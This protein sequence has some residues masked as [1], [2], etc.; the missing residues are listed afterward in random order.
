MVV[1]ASARIV[2]CMRADDLTR[3]QFA[4]LR[5]QVGRIVAYLY[6]LNRRMGEKGFPPDDQ[7]KRLVTDAQKAIGELHMES[8]LPGSRRNGLAIAE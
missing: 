8:G 3:G 7:L 6:R 2:D 1:P 4:A 5:N